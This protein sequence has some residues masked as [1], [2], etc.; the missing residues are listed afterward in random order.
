MVILELLHSLLYEV[1]GNPISQSKMRI[2]LL[3]EERKCEYSNWTWVINSV[4]LPPSGGVFFCLFLP[5]RSLIPQVTT[6]RNMDMP[7]IL[8]FTIYRCSATST[9]YSHVP[10][11][12]FIGCIF[13]TKPYIF[14][15]HISYIFLWCLPVPHFTTNSVI[16]HRFNQ[17]LRN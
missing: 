1:N 12:C 3:R 2:P 17:S 13:I 4:L 5:R 9:L 11:L 14:F 7:A 10:F 8:E 16:P 15:S 6:L